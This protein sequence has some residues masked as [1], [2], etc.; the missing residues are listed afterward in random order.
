MGKQGKGVSV[1][2][3]RSDF[4]RGFEVVIVNYG[5]FPVFSRPRKTS[6]SPGGE[7]AMAMQPDLVEVRREAISMDVTGESER[8]WNKQDLCTRRT[9]EIR[10]AVCR[11]NGGFEGFRGY[12][13]RSREESTAIGGDFEVG[14]VLERVIT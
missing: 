8:G 6:Q 1:G 14:D 5:C 9:G 13:M 12:V 11:E 10:F 4:W 3:E 2:G 7:S